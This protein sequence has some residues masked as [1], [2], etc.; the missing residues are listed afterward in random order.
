MG[1]PLSTVQV[2]EHADLSYRQLNY[3]C[4]SGYFPEQP[5]TM[6]SGTRRRFSDHEADV[7]VVLGALA[8]HVPISRLAELSGLLH[9][10]PTGSWPQSLIVDRSGAVWHPGPDAPPVGIAVNL[11]RLLADA[12]S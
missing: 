8:A 4:A 12:R 11:R 10:T 6:G 3:W 7:A 5:R 1:K 2:C 9:S